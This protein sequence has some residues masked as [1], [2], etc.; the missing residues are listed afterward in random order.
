M[1]PADEG[2]LFFDMEGDPLHEGD[3]E[4]LFG[5]YAKLKGKWTFVDFWAHDRQEEKMA[6]AEFIDFVT[7]HLSEHPHA[8]I[9]HY[10]HYEP[11]ALKRLMSLHGIREAE[12]DQLLRAHKFVDLYTVVRE[13]I[14]ISEPR[15]SIKNLETF[16]MEKREG[17]VT[18]AG[19]SIVYY[20]KWRQTHDD[21]LLRKIRDYNGDDCKSTYLLREWLDKINTQSTAGF[22]P[23]Q[24]LQCHARRLC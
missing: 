15:Y 2:D 1:P 23:Q 21:D 18:S 14:R 20:E 24:A 6:F 4:C 12:V 10:A 9:Y 11:T 3:L 16:Y 5:I 7:T 17:D 22:P 13:A 8:H 19:A